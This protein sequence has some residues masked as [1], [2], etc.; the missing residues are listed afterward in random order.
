RAADRRR[1]DDQH[2]GLDL[3]AADHAAGQAGAGQPPTVADQQPRGDGLARPQGPSAGDAADPDRGGAAGGSDAG[4]LARGA[5]R[6]ETR[7]AAN[8]SEPAAKRVRLTEGPAGGVRK[9][10]LEQ[11]AKPSRRGVT[12]WVESDGRVYWSTAENAIPTHGDGG[13]HKDNKYID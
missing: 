5:G 1:R 8:A 2:R 4:P 13:N 12:L 9:A 10:A 7:A 6:G 11:F 3:V